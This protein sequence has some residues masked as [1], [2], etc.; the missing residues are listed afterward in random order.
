MIKLASLL[1]PTAIVLAAFAAD[2]DAAPFTSFGA[3]ASPLM[4][5][6]STTLGPRRNPVVVTSDN[7]TAGARSNAGLVTRYIFTDNLFLSANN[8]F[9]P[10]AGSTRPNNDLY[11]S[12][13]GKESGNI[14][15]LL[16]YVSWA[17]SGSRVSAQVNYGP[18]FLW[19]PGHTELN[20]VRHVLNAYLDT[21]VIE[22]YFFIDITAQANQALINPRLNTGFDALANNDAFAQTASL[23]VTPRIQFPIAA[24]RF[25][26]VEFQPGFGAVGWSTGA[27]NG[28]RTT[29][30][31]T[32]TTLR[33]TSG[34]MFT[35]VPWSINW[36]RQQFNTDTN[37]GF[38]RFDTRVGYIFGPRYRA[39]IVLGYDDGDYTAANGR[40]SGG[41]WELW[42]RW[43]P[44]TSSTFEVG[45]GQAYYGNLFRFR[46]SH[47]H[48]R[49]ALQSRYDVDVEN[50]A[51]EILNQQVVP[52]EDIFGNPI[53]DPITGNRVVR[54]SITTPALVE[55]TYL[56]DR[57]Q[58][59]LGYSRGRNLVRWDWWTTRRNYNKSDLDTLDNQTRVDYSRRLSRRLSATMD[60]WFWDHTEKQ[61]SQYDYNQQAVYLGL[62]YQL[63]RRT[64]L[65]AQIGRQNRD[66]EYPEGSFSENRVSLGLAFQ[67]R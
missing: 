66:A 45:A 6:G 30:P 59:S 57:F 31:Q 19:Y 49:W 20:G 27:S 60:V 14:F 43:T 51:A 2:A 50:A 67:L 24:G 25:A 40:T 65:D 13:Q 29:T 7:N 44:K 53:I 11:I 37:E 61:D 28:G 21:E 22:R 8:Q 41:R 52:V 4:S 47:R 32:N 10:G 33:I 23:F 12:G 15:Q 38:G 64:Y 55:D 5:T 56:R 3:S 18:S 42:F 39:D 46:A 35:T 26:R 54:D 58:L 62:N 36:Q 9:Q 48:K 17:R 34:S 1:P 63:G 16:P